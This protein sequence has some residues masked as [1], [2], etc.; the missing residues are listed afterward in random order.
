MKNIISEMKS[1]V[2]GIIIRLN[3]AEENAS[4][5]KDGIEILKLTL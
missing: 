5:F 1:L 4:E 3:T 2:D